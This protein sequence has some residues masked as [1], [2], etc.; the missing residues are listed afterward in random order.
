[1]NTIKQVQQL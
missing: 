1:M